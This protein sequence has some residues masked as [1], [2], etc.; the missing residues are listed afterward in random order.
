[1]ALP[2]SMVVVVLDA[3]E[4]EEDEVGRT[5]LLLSVPFLFSWRFVKWMLIRGDSFSLFSFL[6]AGNFLRKTRGER[7][8][9]RQVCTEMC[10]GEKASRCL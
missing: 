5:I 6:Q 3:E 9:G 2:P 7:G 10:A 1:M 8:C 4:E